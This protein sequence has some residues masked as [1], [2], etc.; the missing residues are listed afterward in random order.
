MGLDGRAAPVTPT[1]QDGKLVIPVP[2]EEAL[3]VR[4]TR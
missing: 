4:L 1:A 3:A 2:G